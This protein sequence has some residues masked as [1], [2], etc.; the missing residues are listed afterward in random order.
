MKERVFTLWTLVFLFINNVVSAQSEP[1]NLTAIKVWPNER[2]SNYPPS[3]AIDGDIASFTWSTQTYNMSPAYIAVSFGQMMQ[4]DRI[5][6]FKDTDGTGYSPP[7]IYRKEP[8]NTVHDGRRP[9][10]T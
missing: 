8:G 10:G 5:R 7:H 4:V 6:I 9:A 3:D 2:T 1:I